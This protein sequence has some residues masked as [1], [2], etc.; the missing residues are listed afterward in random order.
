MVS[1]KVTWILKE[2]WKQQVLA[3]HGAKASWSQSARPFPSICFSWGHCLLWTAQ[4]Q[5]PFL[6]QQEED[7]A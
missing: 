7:E 6:T 1:T 5:R 2:R 4:S 3:L